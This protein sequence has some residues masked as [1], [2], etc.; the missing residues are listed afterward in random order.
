MAELGLRGV[1]R[2][3]RVRT[4][5]ADQC[6]ARP[7]DHVNRD[8]TAPDR[9][10]RSA[11][12]GSWPGQDHRVRH[13]R[14]LASDRRLA[15]PRHDADRAAAGRP[16]DGRVGPCPRRRGRRR[17]GAPQRC[18]LEVLRRPLESAQ[19]T[20]IRYAD[21]LTETGAVASIGSVGDSYD[22]TMVESV[23]GLYKTEC[24]RL[25]GPFRTLDELEWP[26]CP[27]STTSTSTGSTRPSGTS[28]L[29]SSSRTITVRSTQGR[30]RCRENSPSTKPGAVHIGHPVPVAQWWVDRDR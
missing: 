10:P 11:R 23:I 30:S 4:T 18:G 9:G 5:V 20:A 27:G 28:R 21:R 6:A 26:P 7:D 8:F 19:Y 13:R 14:V 2:G 22:N 24:V 16:E 25:D 12:R 3:R 17:A 15:H 29:P 1:V